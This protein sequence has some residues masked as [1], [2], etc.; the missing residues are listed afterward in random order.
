MYSKSRLLPGDCSKNMLQ[1]SRSGRVFY[2]KEQRAWQFQAW[3]QNHLRSH[4][5]FYWP[6]QFRFAFLPLNFTE[7]SKDIKSVRI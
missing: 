7:T 4:G 2:S 6:H 5:L 3:V 1:K